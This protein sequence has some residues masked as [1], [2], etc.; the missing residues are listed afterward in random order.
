MNRRTIVLVHGGNGGAGFASAGERLFHPL[1]GIGAWRARIN[2]ARPAGRVEGE[3]E[4][5]L[6]QPIFVY[7]F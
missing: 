5:R 6:L 1:L 3:A 2:V 4:V 7:R